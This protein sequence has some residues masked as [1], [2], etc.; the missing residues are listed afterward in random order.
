MNMSRTV[1]ELNSKEWI[2][3]TQMFG[4]TIFHPQVSSVTK[5]A[6]ILIYGIRRIKNLS[7]KR[8]STLKTN[9]YH[10]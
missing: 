8:F 2:S 6:Y 4:G 3:G 9:G 5:I 10:E 1:K 7:K